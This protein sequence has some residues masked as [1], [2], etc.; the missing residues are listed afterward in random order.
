M[1]PRGPSPGQRALIDACLANGVPFL[2]SS[3]GTMLIAPSGVIDVVR[4]ITA[5]GLVVLGFEGFE[6]ERSGRHHPRLDLIFDAERRPDI[7]DPLTVV[8]GWPPDV[9]IDVAVQ[10]PTPP[11]R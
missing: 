2:W 9:W 7:S 8:A 1:R 3:P 11:E 5:D 4:S 6:L 10:V